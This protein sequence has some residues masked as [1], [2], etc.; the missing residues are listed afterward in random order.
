MFSACFWCVLC[1]DEQARNHQRDGSMTI[2]G[3]QGSAPNY[4]PNSYGYGTP[5][6]LFANFGIS[7]LCRRSLPWP[8]PVLLFDV[9]LPKRS[10]E[11]VPCASG[12][13]MPTAGDRLSAFLLVVWLLR[14]SMF[15][16]A[17]NCY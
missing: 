17:G 12:L 6:S 1:G 11:V 5:R 16:D 8:R 7:L 10:D 13:C 4:F 2:D 9:V 14:L 15:I 3:N